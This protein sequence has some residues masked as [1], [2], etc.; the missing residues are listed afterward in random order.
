MQLG[1]KCPL[2]FFRIQVL[3]E[4]RNQYP[5]IEK[6]C[7]ENDIDKSILSRF[8]SRK[9]KDFKVQTLKRIAKG[10][11]KSLEIKLK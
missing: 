5:S 10:L 8:L 4:I 6:F 11:N 2:E 9:Q 1:R 3:S 7:F